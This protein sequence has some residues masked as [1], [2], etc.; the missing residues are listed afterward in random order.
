MRGELQDR[1]VAKCERQRNVVVTKR[2]I[3]MVKYVYIHPLPPA[4]WYG[5]HQRVYLYTRYIIR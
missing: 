1:A 4:L 5:K 3:T 2:T